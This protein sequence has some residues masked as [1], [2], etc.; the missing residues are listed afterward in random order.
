MKVFATVMCRNRGVFDVIA[1]RGDR[2]RAAL[3]ATRTAGNKPFSPNLTRPSRNQ[4]GR[5]WGLTPPPLTGG[6][7]GVGEAARCNGCGPYPP[8]PNPLPQGEGGEGQQFV[9]HNKQLQ[10]LLLAICKHCSL[11]RLTRPSRNQTGQTVGGPCPPSFQMRTSPLRWARST[12]RE[13]QQMRRVTCD[14]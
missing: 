1:A 3:A 9:Q 7:R 13:K 8:P 2:V 12:L 5:P 11:K 10:T 6:G 4:T 14:M